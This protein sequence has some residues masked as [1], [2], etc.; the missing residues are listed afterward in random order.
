[1]NIFKK[2]S[3]QRFVSYSA[4]CLLVCAVAVGTWRLVTQDMPVA[5][6]TAIPATATTDHQAQGHSCEH[7]TH[8]TT[9]AIREA[10]S[11]ADADGVSSLFEN[12]T[13]EQWWSGIAIPH[14]HI[15]PREAL[16]AKL[17]DAIPVSL[18]ENVELNGSLIL[19]N[20]QANGTQVY[21]LKLDDTGF[22]LHLM[23][24]ADGRVQGNISKQGHPVAYR[25]DGGLDSLTLTRVAISQVLC[26]GWE[27]EKQEVSLGLRYVGEGTDSVFSSVP[28]FNSRPGAPFVIYLDFDGETVS[29]TQW[30]TEFA[31]GE[32]VIVGP[33]SYNPSEIQRIADIVAEDFRGFDVNVTTDRAVFDTA[34]VGTRNMCIFTPDQSWLLDDIGFEIGGIA[35]LNSFTTEQPCWAFNSGVVIG[36]LTASHEIGH[37]LG[38]NHDGTSLDEYYAGTNV[39]GPIM[40]A[41]F[42]APVTQ[43]S[44]GEYTDA[45]NQ[46]D[47]VAMIAGTLGFVPDDYG[48]NEFSALPLLTDGDGNVEFSG[49]VSSEDDLDIFSFGISSGTATIMITPSGATEALNYNARARILDESG[50]VVSDVSLPGIMSVDISQSL[51]VGTYYL[52]ISAGAEGPWSSSYGAYGSIGSYDVAANIPAPTPGDTD[53]D[54]LTDDEELVI[55]TDPFDADTDADSIS[56]RKEVYPF[57]IIPG[58][59]TFNEALADAA[60][61]GGR[62][63]TIESPERLYQIK[64]GLLEN[65]HPFAVLPLNYDPEVD[66]DQRLW[67]GGHDIGEDGRFRWLD[68]QRD[69][70]TPANELQGPEIGS[71]VFAQMLSGDDVL[72]NVVNIDAL[73]AGREVIASGIPAGTTITN[74]DVAAR[75]ATISNPVGN[76]FTS[77]VGQVVVSNGGV[78]Y[79]EAPTV[80]FNP[81]GA[82]AV[83]SVSNGQITSILVTNGGSY[84]NPPAISFTGGNGGGGG[85][86][87]VLTRIGSGSIRSITLDTPGAGYTSTPTVVIAGGNSQISATAVASINSSGV[88]TAVTIINPGSGYTSQPTITLAG[89]GAATD[90]TAT[91]SLYVAA[92]RIYSPASPEVYTNWNTILPGNRNNVPEGVF[93]DSGTAF[94]WSTGQ[95]TSGYGYVLEIPVTDPLDADTDGDNL[96]DFDESF[97]HGSN[98]LDADTDGD[99]LDDFSE[100]F[101]N[102]TDPLNPDTDADGLT[103]GDEVA[104]GTDPN[105][106]DTDGDGYN[107]SDTFFK[108]SSSTL[109]CIKFIHNEP[110]LI[111]VFVRWVKDGLNGGDPL[112]PGSFMIA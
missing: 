36:A 77:R 39:W 60:Q 49:I 41:P 10:M 26:A 22:N 57:T 67:I 83:A 85:A 94:R 62:L 35:Y 68:R 52:E 55:G 73:T 2:P 93:L 15:V 56:D 109:F 7:C 19:R 34:P 48:D 11:F 65:P 28:L 78:G 63:A 37:T 107:D 3:R 23:E 32:D 103:D 59:F 102:L 1:M 75:T 105:L 86:E 79:T 53:G 91:A 18:G 81:P 71:S 101:V 97:V 30:N 95:V 8:A 16:I 100:I 51:N 21:G 58:S 72:R 50:G 25:I 45:N 17:G 9:T 99:G 69:Y 87:A 5:G 47:D 46:E 76:D 74:I 42:N 54:G 24:Y 112:K 14:Q 33:E 90:A 31:E 6:A 80:S 27:K 70:V 104:R 88:V 43:W 29:G 98:S 110:P 82:T 108:L 44:Q 38:L 106:G 96:S 92:G 20:T 66:L 12:V 40:G 4:L 13:E 111:N 64:R 84:V 61:R 89:G